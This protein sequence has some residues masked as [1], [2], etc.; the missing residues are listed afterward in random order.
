MKARRVAIVLAI[1]IVILLNGCGGTQGDTAGA[2]T[3]P[4]TTSI[5]KTPQASQGKPDKVHVKKFNVDMNSS[6]SDVTITNSEEVS[7]LFAMVSGMPQVPKDQICPAIA[8]AHYELTFLQG[9]KVVMMATADLSGC[10]QVR[11]SAGDK[12][13]PDQAFWREL[14][15]AVASATPQA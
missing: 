11:L 14:N 3:P 12:R 10:G 8:G 2:A 1:L 9:E 7:K 6:V 4:A 15:Q 5:T 13:Q